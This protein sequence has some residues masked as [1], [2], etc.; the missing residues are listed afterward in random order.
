MIELQKLSIVA[1]Q[2]T[3]SIAIVNLDGSINWVNHGF[4]NTHNLDSNKKPLKATNIFE[5]QGLA[6]I[7]TKFYQCVQSGLTVDFSTEIVVNDK[8]TRHLQISL[9]PAFDKASNQATSIIL[10]ETDITRLKE[11]EHKLNKQ[12]KEMLEITKSWKSR[13]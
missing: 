11:K 9:T 1:K 4:E 2:T 7:K 3:N 10:I 13:L 12:N 5:I 6:K 8:S